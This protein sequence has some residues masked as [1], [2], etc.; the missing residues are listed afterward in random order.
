MPT[1]RHLIITLIAMLFSMATTANP[2]TENKA[3]SHVMHFLQSTGNRMKVRGRQDITLAKVITLDQ[4][5]GG[6]GTPMVYIFN[7][8]G[9][10]GFV[11]AAADD[12][13]R[14]ILG[15]SDKCN[16]DPDNMPDNMLAFL[17]S[18]AREISDARAMGLKASD[19]TEEVIAGRED[20]E[21]MIAV[22]WDQVEPYNDQCIFD[23]DRCM[24][25]C[26]ATAM[27]QIMYYWGV[28]GRDGLRFRHGAPAI[29]SYQTEKYDI[30]ALEAL[31][32]FDWDSMDEGTA[33]P[34]S[35]AAKQA[36][37]QLM[38]YCGQ[39]CHMNYGVNSSGTGM[40]TSAWTS[41]GYS[42]EIKQ[43]Y[44]YALG[45]S[46]FEEEIY[47]EI[48]HRRPVQ[49]ACFLIDV[50]HCFVC[51]GYDSA[52][53]FYHYNF[54]WGGAQDCNLSLTALSVRNVRRTSVDLYAL[55]D[56]TPPLEA[57]AVLDDEGTLTFYYDHQKD[58]RT[59]TIYPID[60]LSE[61]NYWKQDPN[62]IVIDKSF[63]YYHFYGEG[64]FFADFCNVSNIEGLENLDFSHVKIMDYAFANC[65]NLRE[66][67]LSKLD[68]SNVEAMDHMFYNCVSLRELDLS[69]F[70][71]PEDSCATKSMLEGCSSLEKLTVPSSMENISN[72][73]CLNLASSQSPCLIS[74]PDGFDFGTKV[75]QEGFLWKGGH[76]KV[77][78]DVL[79]I[80]S[81]G[82]CTYCNKLDFDF[83]EIT[84]FKG[85]V[86]TGFDAE[87]QK[88][89]ATRVKYTLLGGTGILVKGTPGCYNLK[90]DYL[91]GMQFAN[92]LE[93]TL[94]PTLLRPEEGEN[95]NLILANG[96][97]GLGFYRF[98]E[99]FTLGA[100]KAYLPLP[101][102]VLNTA[103]SNVLNIEFA[104]DETG[105]DGIQS[106]AVSPFAPDNWYT[107]DGRQ[108]QGSPVRKGIYLQNGR[109][110]VVK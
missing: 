26:V 21:P 56:I 48:K 36:V 108:L 46:S 59:G 90:L 35:E 97:D 34:H 78:R 96:D 47:Q 37:A 30:P 102:S 31:E 17:Q 60:E 3:K 9:G 41:F 32:S 110:V 44:S 81:V 61:S 99:E 66:L 4:S 109:K 11:I 75:S 106:A 88:V 40:D 55:V 45:M 84:D 12:V 76:F 57:Y 82:M 24:T 51:D 6:D 100:N 91:S 53:G 39:A 16:L 72:T 38:R 93:G 5:Q 54:G 29:A 52:T 15:Y 8:S 20:V 103:G 25:G 74:I 65:F 105:A 13:A 2:I 95:T 67:D 89:T 98:T 33:T 63:S 79:T 80:P 58:K 69:N 49:M 14:P 73:A 101:T 43:I 23:G 27:A 68:V 87:H 1:M 42:D 94:S 70:V 107:L 64:F 86:V 28:T 10:R 77:G 71:F 62:L 85:Y 22:T 19:V 83:S 92:M 104:E 7:I 18:Y 50:N